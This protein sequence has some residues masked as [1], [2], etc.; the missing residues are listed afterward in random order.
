MT[1]HFEQ[2]AQLTGQ[3]LVVCSRCTRI[4]P[5]D[6]FTGERK[7]R[8]GLSYKC[9]ECARGYY[10]M[11]KDAYRL[12]RYGYQAAAGGIVIDFTAAQKAER[13]A[14]WGGSCWMCGIENASE[15]DH[16]KPISKGG[17]HCLSNCDQSASHAMRPKV[18][19]GRCR[20]WS[21][22]PISV[23]PIRVPG[24]M[25]PPFAG[26]ASS[27]PVHS[28]AQHHSSGRTARTPENT[29][30][31]PASLRQGGRVSS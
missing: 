3:L 19:V 17:S 18:V 7:N 21:Y 13:F 24:A 27:G 29:A 20:G 2:Q 31:R 25:R 22:V 14:L 23:T 8:N 4:L 28:A 26:H 1:A 15:E 9:K 11:N 6:C 12:R 5:A 10:E 16:V 30:P